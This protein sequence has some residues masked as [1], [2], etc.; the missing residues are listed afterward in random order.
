MTTD[1]APGTIA[2]RR[3]PRTGRTEFR[4][5]PHGTEHPDGGAGPWTPDRAAAD[6]N[7]TA[8]LAVDS[9]R[10]CAESL[11]AWL[12]A[13]PDSGEAARVR[14]AA[15][16]E[17]WRTRDEED[18]APRRS[19]ALTRRAVAQ[20]ELVRRANI[21]TGYDSLGRTVTLSFTPGGR[22]GNAWVSLDKDPGSGPMSYP[23]SV[24]T[25]TI[26]GGNLDALRRIASWAYA[27]VRDSPWVDSG[28]P[29]AVAFRAW[30]EDVE[31]LVAELAAAQPMVAP[32]D[33]RQAEY[34]RRCPDCRAEPNQPCRSWST[35]AAMHDSHRARRADTD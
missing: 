27:K 33:P 23:G 35:G 25:F 16:D 3:N 30:T 17:L 4:A 7:L 24:E 8:A 6:A 10:Q 5:Y 9:N 34:A 19:L 21:V 32:T 20:A 26:T 18:T 12:S 14:D 1:T 31:A 11:A 29:G 15:E 2:E 28:R 22:G 13:A